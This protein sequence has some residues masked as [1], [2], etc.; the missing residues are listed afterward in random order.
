MHS[1]HKSEFNINQWQRYEY[2]GTPVYLQPQHP[3]W[4][5]PDENADFL[6][7]S[8]VTGTEATTENISEAQQVFVQRLP[9]AQATTYPG[10]KAL[11]SA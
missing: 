4:F 3:T 5:V 1:L 2:A 10:G 7:K 8:R 11:L 9:H 6:L